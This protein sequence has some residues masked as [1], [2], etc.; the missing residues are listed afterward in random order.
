MLWLRLANMGAAILLCV[1]A[2]LTLGTTPDFTTAVLAIY[3]FV[4]AVMLFCFELA[5]EMVARVIADNMGFFYNAKGRLVFIILC[6]ATCRSSFSNC[7]WMRANG[8]L[9]MLH[10]KF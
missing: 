3:V 9:T 2:V 6:V 10:A 1:L 4:F 8:G 7:L 5:L